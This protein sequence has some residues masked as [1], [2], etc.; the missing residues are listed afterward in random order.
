[1]FKNLHVVMNSFVF[2]SRILKETASLAGAGM[3]D[4]VCIAA[5]HEDGLEE[6]ETLD[7]RRVVRRL[8]L[9][10]RHWPRSLPVQLLKYVEFCARVIREA[11]R[12]G[13]EV[14]SVHSLALLPLGVAL[15]WVRGARLVYDAHE[16]ETE[17]FGLNGLRQS[18]ARIVERRLIPYADLVIVVGDGIADWY[19]RAYRLNNVVTVMNCPRYQRPAR[20]RRLHEALSIPSDRRIV[21][22]QGL[23]VPGRGIEALLLLFADHDDGAHV[24][25]FMGFGELEGL[26]D[27]QARRHSNIYRHPA[28]QPDV[29]L[30]Y[31]ASA[32]V[33]IAYINNPSL[34]DRLCLPNKMFEYIMAGLPVIVNNA[35]EMS[36]VVREKGIG[37]VLTELTVA[38]LATALGEIERRDQ[39]AMRSS[40]DEA[41]RIY[42]W[43]NQE[44]EMLRGYE[45][46]VC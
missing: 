28:V 26:I 22:Y 25:V 19:R 43:E 37:A 39:L 5:I 16:L 31:T 10:S 13:A 35:P 14:V 21:L 1:M 24:V 38:S 27:Q 44:R 29:V 3:A 11:M 8:R 34:N 9:R 12:D 20:T 41:A 15:K 2:G 45:A 40:L 30:D 33:G 18:L 6:R 4:R 17:T 32:D 23:L 36:R 42:S 7:N 46:Y